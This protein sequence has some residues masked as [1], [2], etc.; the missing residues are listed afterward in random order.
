MSIM[1]KIYK[2]LPH[3]KRGMLFYLNQGMK[4]DVDTDLKPHL[5]IELV[6]EDMCNDVCAVRNENVQRAFENMVR[7]GQVCVF[8]YVD[9]RIAGHAACVLPDNMEG[10]FRVKKSAYIHYCYVD[11]KHRGHN[12]Y[13]LMLQQIIRICNSEQNIQRFTMMT[14]RENIPS[15]HGLKKVGFAFLKNYWYIEWWRFIWKKVTV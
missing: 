9:G 2:F 10:A 15:Q 1:N 12:I 11:S 13:P 5:R 3:I 6:K 7:K 8:A 14:S 4:V